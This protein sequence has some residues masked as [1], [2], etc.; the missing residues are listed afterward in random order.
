MWLLIIVATIIISLL[1]W[2]IGSE[3]S[4]IRHILVNKFWR[5][6]TN[7]EE[8]KEKHSWGTIR[9]ILKGKS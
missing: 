3:L 7:S 1:L 2:Y 5:D 9:N 4:S 8:Y 6:Y